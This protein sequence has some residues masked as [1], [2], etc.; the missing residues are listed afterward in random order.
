M[1][2]LQCKHI[3]PD[4]YRKAREAFFNFNVIY[5][6][7]LKKIKIQLKNFYI[8]FGGMPRF[9]KND[10]RKNYENI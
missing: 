4:N 10:G 2:Y 5:F 1:T 8:S 6:I 7:I 9:K 3:L